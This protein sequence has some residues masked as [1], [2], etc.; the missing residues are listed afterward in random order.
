MF[1]TRYQWRP[2]LVYTYQPPE[3]NSIAWVPL[4]YG[5]PY[6]AYTQ[7]WR[8]AV[9]PQQAGFVPRFYREQ[10]GIVYV[11]N[12]GFNRRERARKADKQFIK[13]YENYDVAKAPV[14]RVAKPDRVVAVDRVAKVRP[15][16]KVRNRAVVVAS[17]GQDAKRVNRRA[18]R[19][20]R[21]VVKADNKKMEARRPA[22]GVA[23]Q[24][25]APRVIKQGGKMRAERGAGARAKAAAPRDNA[26]PKSGKG[27]K[28]NKQE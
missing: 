27:G 21:P 11:S 25:P 1:N 17:D 20:D 2:A 12:D 16:E 8:S 14:Y 6:V 23:R 19:A 28:R 10:R 22:A 13:R 24:K 9:V 18:A 7:P 15:S 4:A 5:E 26:Q 3:S